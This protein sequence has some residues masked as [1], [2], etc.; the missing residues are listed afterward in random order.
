MTL[1]SLEPENVLLLY[2][3]KRDFA[4]LVKVKDFWG[5]EIILN[6]ADYL[7]SLHIE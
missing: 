2:T 1:W 7:S 5:G 6:Y 4:D 3:D